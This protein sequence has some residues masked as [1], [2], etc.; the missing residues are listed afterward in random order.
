MAETLTE[1]QVFIEF[2]KTKLAPAQNRMKCYADQKRSDRVFQ[3]GDEVLL[4][5]QPYAQSSLVNRPCPKLVMK[6]YG[7]YKIL[8]KVGTSAYK[9]ERPL[10]SQIPP[11]FHVSQLKDYTSNH[12]PVFKELPAPPVLDI[13]QLEPELILDRHLTKKGNSAITRVLIK[14]SSLPVESTTW[15]DYY[16]LKNRFPTAAA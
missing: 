16:I 11:V 2:L 7:P 15:E 8:E 3:V 4:K 1:R 5:L 12:T 13:A 6:Y 10:G 9:L 14:W